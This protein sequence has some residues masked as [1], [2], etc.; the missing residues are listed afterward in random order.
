MWQHTFAYVLLVVTTWL[1]KNGYCSDSS[2][3]DVVLDIVEPRILGCDISP[4]SKHPE[5]SG[6]VQGRQAR[7]YS[8]VNLKDRVEGYIE[9]RQS[10]SPNC[11]A[12]ANGARCTNNQCCSQFG[13]CG[14]GNAWCSTSAGCQPSYGVCGNVST[15]TTSTTSTSTP[16]SSSSSTSSS[17][18]PSASLTVSLNGMCGNSTTCTGFGGGQCCSEYWYCGSGAAWCGEGCHPAFGICSGST[19]L[20]TTLTTTTTTT[21]SPTTSTSSSTSTSASPSATLP[22]GQTATTDG[23]CGNGKSCLEWSGGKCCSQYGYCGSSS[24]YCS[25]ISGCQSAFGTCSSS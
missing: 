15:S 9:Q 2:Q 13:Y 20:T 8:D 19:N 6:R 1:L 10:S 3:G 22:A 14:T 5:S 16:S 23:T 25:P 7:S 11:G 21:T 12:S 17:P 24:T 18:S 4:P